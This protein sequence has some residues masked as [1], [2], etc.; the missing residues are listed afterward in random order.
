MNT[1]SLD[2][3]KN[4]PADITDD[5]ETM[6]Y[7]KRLINNDMLDYNGNPIGVYNDLFLYDTQTKKHKRLTKK[8]QLTTPV[9]SDDKKYVYAS[10]YRGSGGKSRLIK[11]S[12]G[13]FNGGVFGIFGNRAKQGYE[14]LYE[15]VNSLVFYKALSPDGKR[16]V[17]VERSAEFG[18]KLQ[19][20]EIETGEITTLIQ[21]D[22]GLWIASPKFIDNNRISIVADL[23]YITDN[24]M[25]YEID[26]SSKENI[27]WKRVGRDKIGFQSAVLD[28]DSRLVYVSHNSKGYSIF[29]YEKSEL[30]NEI[31]SI[32]TLPL[33]SFYADNNIQKKLNARVLRG[34][35]AV[36]ERRKPHNAETFQYKEQPAFGAIPYRLRYHIPTFSSDN[37]TGL[38]LGMLHSVALDLHSGRIFLEK[39]TIYLIIVRGYMI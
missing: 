38:R 33:P 25:M 12:I 13:A 6:V 10:Q 16:M 24:T 8:Q 30:E 20:L 28:E 15:G 21:R 9:I 5:G 26:V 11:I 23:E 19:L 1:P 14:V 4:Q 17:F 35:E 27:V 22:Y 3:Y 7:V 39:R 36:K 18:V 34:T 2:F 32:D 29:N 31:I 37:I